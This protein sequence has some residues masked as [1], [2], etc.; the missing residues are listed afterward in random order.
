MV[1]SAFLAGLYVP[2]ALFPDWLHAL[3]YATPFPAI[4]QI[5]VDVI[6]GRETGGDAFALV[7]QQVGWL[8]VTCL[9][10]RC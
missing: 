5:P 1:T 10:G 4:L 7:A 3:A 8:L 2:V 9:V 6:S